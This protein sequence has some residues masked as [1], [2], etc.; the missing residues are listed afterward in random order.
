MERET[1][2]RELRQLEGQNLRPIA[3]RLGVTV[4]KG[5]KLNKGWV[6][7]TIERFLG[8]PLNSSRSPNF[9]SWELKVVSLKYLRNGTLVPKE[10]MA[11]TMID[12]VEVLAREFEES[13]LYTKMRRILAVARDLREQAGKQHPAIR[14]SRL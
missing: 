1:A 7:H 2:I 11:I 13:H 4:W 6:G 14:H 9:G 3:D 10:T 5:D 12:P 8:L